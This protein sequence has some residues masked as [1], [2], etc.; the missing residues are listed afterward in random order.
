MVEFK[1]EEKDIREEEAGCDPQRAQI[2]PQ[3][4]VVQDK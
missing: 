3:T 2:Y 1:K 4:V